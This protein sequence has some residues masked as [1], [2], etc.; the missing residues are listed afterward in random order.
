MD[1][2]MVVFSCT[3]VLSSM[4]GMYHKKPDIEP[5]GQQAAAGSRTPHKQTLLHSTV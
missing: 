3:L 2:S 5:I 4:N 1:Y